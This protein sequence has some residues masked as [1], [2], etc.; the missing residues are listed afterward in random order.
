MHNPDLK[1]NSYLHDTLDTCFKDVKVVI[2]RTLVKDAPDVVDE[3]YSVDIEIDNPENF[4][5]YAVCGGT[6]DEA[7]TIA[8][9]VSKTIHILRDYLYY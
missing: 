8:I 3:R 9:A 2:W 5:R 4:H 6:L 7:V 1:V